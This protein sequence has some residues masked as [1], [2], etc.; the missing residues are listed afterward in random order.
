MKRSTQEAIYYAAVLLISL[1]I[2]LWSGQSKAQQHSQFYTGNNLYSDCTH[3]SAVRRTMCMG[4]VT[5]VLDAVT[6][7]AVCHPPSVTVGQA[8]DMVV[9]F[10]RQRPD[11]RNQAADAIVM[12]AMA[13]A[14]PCAQRPTN[15]RNSV[16]EV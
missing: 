6:G 10:M 4:Y 3:E 5:G 15:Q 2:G 7:V 9:Q 16:R 1:A 14:F 12:A 13:A 11:L 8:T